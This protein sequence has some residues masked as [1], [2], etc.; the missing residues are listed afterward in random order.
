MKKLFISVISLLLVMQVN[1]QSK[2]AVAALKNLE[3]VKKE[4]EHPKKGKQPATWIKLGTTYIECYDAP[5]TGIWQ[6]ANQ[7]ETKLLLKDQQIISSEQK[8]INGKLFNVDNYDDKSLYYDEKGI[9]AAWTITKPT[10]SE[11]ALDLS[12]E[13]FNKA[14]QLDGEK[15]KNSKKIAE[16]LTGLKSRYT[17]EGMS[18]Y[19]LGDNANASKYFEKSMEVSAH[20]TIGQLDTV[21]AYYAGVTAA[22]TSE[23]E[24]AIKL[25]T[26]C[27]ENGYEQN[28][29]TYATLAE[30][31]KQNGDTTKA[32]EILA[33]AFEKYPTSQNIL[34][35]LVNLYMETNDDPNKILELLKAAQANEPNNASLYYAEGNVYSKLGKLEDAV[36]S[37]KKASEVD[38]SYE[39]APFA[40]GAA[41]YDN[42]VAI[43]EKAQN[44][45]DQTKYEA[46]IAEMEKSLE[47]AIAPFEKAYS[48]AKNPQLK[49]ATAE[50]LKNIYFRFRE[51]NEEYKANYEKYNKIFSE[52]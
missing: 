28:G 6:G 42:A 18:Y 35:T 25:L 16:V 19:S 32:K 9:L 14:T 3:K 29:D 31:Y 47:S 37:F 48:I 23:K 50:Y 11:N 1:A 22:A 36:K 8:E 38:P 43:Q 30:S 13:A 34:V 45:M 49:K 20:P 12:L 24:R 7:S 51:K 46:L 21:M 5:I 26:K 4:T 52:E 2:N 39:F 40:E 15:G 44:E 33:T 27:I 10:I 17:N 41:Y